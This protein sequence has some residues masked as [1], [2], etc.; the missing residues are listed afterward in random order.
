V[1]NAVHLEKLCQGPKAW[2]AWRNENPH[3]VPDLSAASLA[4]AERQFG[5]SNG[6]PVNLRAVN[7]EGANLRFATLTEADLEGARLNGADLLHARLDR[8]RLVATDL[9]DAMLDNADLT[10]ADFER[11]VIVGTS[12]VNARNLTQAQIDIAFG[13][14]STLLPASLTPPHAWFPV[15]AGDDG[16]FDDY[17]AFGADEEDDLYDILGLSDQATQDEARSAYRVLV[18]KLHPDVNPDDRAAQ[19]RFKLVSTAYKIL[20][21]PEKRAAY[22][23]GEIDGEGRIRPEF[24]AKQQ[25][26]KY[27]FRYYAAAAAS[28]CLAIGV[29]GVVWYLVLNSG[30]KHA[31]RVRGT[32]NAAA[33]SKQSERLGADPVRMMPSGP[34]AVSV[35]PATVPEDRAERTPGQDAAN[36]DE[37]HKTAPQL[38][39]AAA[40][41]PP[42]TLSTL[43]EAAVQPSEAARP[44]REAH[45]NGPAETTQDVPAR[46]DTSAIASDA[47]EPEAGVSAD[48]AEQVDVQSGETVAEA[49][50]SRQTTHLPSA[51]GRDAISGMFRARAVA[52]TLARSPVS[53]TASLAPV[54]LS[55]DDSES[56]E[57]VEPRSARRAAKRRRK[58]VSFEQRNRRRVARAIEAAVAEPSSAAAR[59]AERGSQAVSDVLAGGL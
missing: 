5:P 14:A 1:A 25:F 44:L 47:D 27:A 15:V 6:G 33:Y 41:V 42:S 3:I 43:R 9:T 32:E 31:N 23:R 30:A 28:L 54:S 10:D 40:D 13:D 37:Q 11:T 56:A 22:D 24:E 45:K 59:R 34:L 2:N 7:L 21:D 35:D 29:L 52:Q 55:N 26:R 39:L 57:A 50:G 38:P 58:A 46:R 53:N 36:A 8:A 18:K 17:S 20:G 4:L 16:P 51:T 49:S 19:E 12:F 48:A